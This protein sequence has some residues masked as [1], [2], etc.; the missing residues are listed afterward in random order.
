MSRKTTESRSTRKSARRAPRRSPVE[1]PAYIRW[2]NA[3]AA[4]LA[5][6]D[7]ELRDLVHLVLKL[8][9]KHR[10]D[11]AASVDDYLADTAP[12]FGTKLVRWVEVGL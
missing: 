5:T 6:M 8:T 3:H 10:K 12:L 9:P 4:G 7:R 11:W 2:Y 1:V